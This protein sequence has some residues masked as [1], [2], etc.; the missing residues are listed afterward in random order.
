MCVVEVGQYFMTKDTGDFRQFCSVACREYTLPRDDPASQPKGWILEDMRIGPVLEVTTS[1]MYG[2]HGIEIRIWSVS[3]DNSHSWVRI[4][5][6][7][8]KYVIDS[9]HNNTEIP[10]DPLEDQKSQ[11]SVKVIAS[12]SKAK[13]KPQKREPVD[14]A[15]IIPMHERKWIDIEPSAPSLKAYEVSK[16]VISLLR[17]NQTVQREEDGAIQFYKIKF[18]GEIN[19]IFE[20]NSH[21]YSIGLMSV[22]KFAWQQEEVQKGDISIVL[23]I[24]EQSFSS[25]LFKDTLDIISLILHH[26][27]M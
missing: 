5:Y 25:V 4:S 2:K 1:Y 24:W 23:I 3:Q 7:T 20:I 9:N 26:R 17:H 10:A 21:K 15:S 18:P 11:T 13:A 27:T 14:T 16:R 8:V 22:G 19:F 12:R 6:G